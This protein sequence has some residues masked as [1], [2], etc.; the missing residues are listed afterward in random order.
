MST[1]V[2]RREIEEF[3]A[4]VDGRAEAR[5]E[6][7]RELVELVASIRLVELPAM[8]LAVHA[9]LRQRLVSAARTELA[10]LA[11]AATKQ[12]PRKGAR[13]SA[14]AGGLGLRRRLAGLAGAVV[15]AGGGVGLVSVSAQ[16]L[17]GDFLYPVKRATE[18]ADLFVHTGDTADGRILLDHAH[19]RLDE[20]QGL[21]T[22]HGDTAPQTPQT[23]QLINATLVD[24]TSEA[25][26]GGQLLITS[27]QSNPSTST[28]Q[29]LQS[30]TATAAQELGLLSTQLP[31]ATAAAYADAAR[32]V[33]GLV[34]DTGEVCPACSVGGTVQLATA[35]PGTLQDGLLTTALSL[36]PMIL[37]TVPGD[38]PLHPRVHLNGAQHGGTPGKHGILPLPIGGGRNGGSGLTTGG[39][40]AGNG[41][42]PGGSDPLPGAGT[43]GS[44]GGSTGG[45]GSPTVPS[46]T[47]PSPT[48]P[49]P[50]LPSPTPPSPTLP[51]PTLPSPT[52]PAPT[53]PSPTLPSPTLPSPTLPSPTLPSPTLPSPTL[54]S[55]TLSAPT[56][57]APSNPLAG[58]PPAGNDA[59]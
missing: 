32:T 18:S 25:R 52:L 58:D 9:D 54:P 27:Y 39:G 45:D 19:T 16:A 23:P 17:P 7:V 37:Q 48:V 28:L 57:P 4:A 47:V 26:D 36:P 56:V 40:G 8:D 21:L 49:S 11:A 13:Q 5:S 1:P 38:L 2:S 44:G 55:P 24:F 15:V 35:L 6:R 10:P 46:P 3:A 29:P 20:V 22:R 12:Q 33:N 30:F 43:A 14:P 59:S 50:T 42:A 51:S 31:T 41:P 53:L 34:A